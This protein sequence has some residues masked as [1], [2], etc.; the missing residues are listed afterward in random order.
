MRTSAFCTH[1]RARIACSELCLHRY[2]TFLDAG[3]A[4]T[5]YSVTRTRTLPGPE[6]EPELEPSPDQVKGG[7]ITIDA[8]SLSDQFKT[9]NDK[10]FESSGDVAK[11][12]SSPAMATIKA[13]SQS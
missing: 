9:E 11:L 12:E 13:D 6:P 5:I 1:S 7:K 8:G 4:V 10:R 2:Y 3:C